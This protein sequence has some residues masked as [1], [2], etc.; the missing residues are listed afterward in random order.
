MIV[1]IR[2]LHKIVLTLG[3]ITLAQPV[4]AETL[5]RGVNVPGTVSTGALQDAADMGANVLRYQFSDASTADEISN[6]QNYYDRLDEQ[7][8]YLIDVVFPYIDDNSL[9]LTLLID[10]HT[11]PGGFNGCGSTTLQFPQAALFCDP[12]LQTAFLNG[13]ETI[14]TRIIDSGYIDLV[15]GWEILSEPPAGAS[16]LNGA[17]S[18]P[19]LAQN[20]AEII[21]A[22]DEDTNLPIVMNAEYANT[23]KLRKGILLTGVEPVVYGFN[24]YP[25]S[26]FLDQDEN[27]ATVNYP[28]DGSGCKMGNPETSS[29]L[30]K[31]KKKK[32]KNKKNKNKNDATGM[33]KIAEPAMKFAQNNAVPIIVGEFAVS[34]FAPDADAGQYLTDIMNIFEEIGVVGYSLHAVGESSFWDPRILADGT[35]GDNAR[36]TALETFFANNE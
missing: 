15:Y 26:K 18:W 34:R 4:S 36:K 3:L 19:D 33:W 9:P 10:N 30:K 12:A 31:K 11:P 1:T 21:R 20:A 23:E 28:T 8:D 6:V 24:F 29:N 7:L 32:K 16:S 5:Y 22:N 17:L 25:C 2:T 27:D 35:F 14:V 13:W